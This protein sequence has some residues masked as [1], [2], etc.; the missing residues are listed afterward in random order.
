LRIEFEDHSGSCTVFGERNTELAQRDYVYAL[1]GDRTLHAYCDVFQLYDSR[2][3]GIMMMKKTGV[4]HKYSWVYKHDIG[5]VNDPKTMMYIFNIRIFTTQS[6]KEM[7][8]VYCWDGKQF[9]KVILFNSVYKKVKNILIEGQW[10]AARLSK[11][12]DKE[13]LNRLDT[14]KLDSADKMITIE[15]YIKRKNIKQEAHEV[16]A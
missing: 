12:E 7:A 6:N 2:L 15:D 8:S 13:S 1:I 14:F 5:F 4:N 10:Y 3:F 16:L 9:F 11:I